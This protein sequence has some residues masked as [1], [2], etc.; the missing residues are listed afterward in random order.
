MF[1][2]LII[3]F[4]DKVRFPVEI[5]AFEPGVWMFPILISNAIIFTT[6]VLYQKNKL[7]HIK[8]KRSYLFLVEMF[9]KIIHQLVI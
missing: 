2:A 8:T 5:N 6:I 7:P 3:A 9:L 1:P 4:S